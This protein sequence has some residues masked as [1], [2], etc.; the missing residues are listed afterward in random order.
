MQVAG[1]ES[2]LTSQCQLIHTKIMRRSIP[3][4]IMLL[5]AGLAGRSMTLRD[6]LIYARD[7]A[8]DNI[9]ADL[10][11]RESKLDARIAASDLM[12]S[13]N[14]NSSGNLSFGRN[15]D[16]ETNTYD[17]K[18][19]LGESFGVSMSLPLFDGLVRI[20]RLRASRTTARRQGKS[21]ENQRDEISLRVIRAFYNVSYCRAMVAQMEEQLERDLRNLAA[22]KS[23]EK[24]GTKS[25]ADVAEMEAI[26]ASDEYELTNQNNLLSKAYL[27]LRSEMGMELSDEPL[28]LTEE[29]WAGGR[30]DE[31][32]VHPRIAEAELSLR[33][34]R[35]LL[36]VA[37]GAF[38]PRLTLNGGVST[39]YY[40]MLGEAG[41]VGRPFSKQW[42][43][44]MGQ[45]VGLSLS[46]PIFTGLANINSLKRAKIEVKRREATLDKARYEVSRAEVEAQLDL[47]GAEAEL[48]SARTRLDAETVAYAAVQRKF[49]LGA[50]SAIDLYTAST[51][52]AAARAALEGKRIQT[53][54]DRIVVDYYKGVPF[55]AEN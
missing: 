16:P 26:V 45:Y 32:F 28:D 14:L 3:L 7:H 42:N 5:A 15:I 10:A 29:E 35:Y 39:S 50:L 30:P 49:D 22:T 18:T 40:R 19:T 20:N 11:W 41:S 54:I 12:P 17:T 24:V 4:I 37:K 47:D 36:N 6:C 25:G 31:A 13:V 2:G 34:G 48:K 55:I 1:E 46:I 38:S 33:E 52:L 43:D 23:G 9:V 8:P 21:A 27:T 53:I 44:N 51:K